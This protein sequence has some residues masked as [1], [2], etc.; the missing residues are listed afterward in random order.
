MLAVLTPIFTLMSCDS[1]AYSLDNRCPK[2][3]NVVS[4]LGIHMIMQQLII[5]CIIL[6]SY[7]PS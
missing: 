2:F 5:L 1:W 3:V 4:M 7:Y 6:F